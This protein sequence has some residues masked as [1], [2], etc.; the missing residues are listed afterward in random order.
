MSLEEAQAG[1]CIAHVDLDAFYVQVEL[2]QHPSLVGK[3]VGVVQYNPN[4]DLSTLRPDEERIFNSSNGSLIAVG[5]E[6]R[7]KGVKRGMR[8]DDARKVCP[9]LNLV[10]VPVAHGKADLTLY[11][12]SGKQVL[13]ILARLSIAERA[14]IDECYLDISEEAKKR[15]AA[16]SAHPPLPI[17]VDQVHV[18][19]EE[20]DGATEA[21]WHRPVGAWGPG[22]RLLACGAAVVAELRAAVRRELGYSCSAGIAHN[23][24]L[25]KLASGMHKPSQQTVVTLDCVPGLM[26]D[27]PI[28]KL[29]QLGGKFGEEIMAALGITSVGELSAVPLRRLEAVCGHADALWLHRLSRGI[30]DEEVK[31]RQLA[32]SISCGKTFRGHTAL[33][34]FPAVHKWLGEL[35]HE[36]EERIAADR[37]ENERVPRLL[38]V[39]MWGEGGPGTSGGSVSRSCQ[40]R[41]PESEPMAADALKLIKRWASER[42]PGWA[43]TSLYMTASNFQ[44]APTGA[45]TIT[46]FLKPRSGILLTSAT[47]QQSTNLSASSPPAPSTSAQPASIQIEGEP[48]VNSQPVNA[49]ANADCNHAQPGSAPSREA[50][51]GDGSGRDLGVSGLDDT[52]GADGDSERMAA[53][54]KREAA[55]QLWRG[56]NLDAPLLLQCTEEDMDPEVLAALPADIRRELRLALMARRP[57][58]EGAQ[59]GRDNMTHLGGRHLCRNLLCRAEETYIL[60]ATDDAGIDMPFSCRSGTCSS[61]AGKIVSGTLDQ[62]ESQ[63]LTEDKIEA[64]YALLCVSYPQSDLVIETDKEDEVMG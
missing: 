28:P 55:A 46:R 30:D 15:L 58:A 21:W 12:A 3:P 2:K 6:A 59:R 14:S 26:A 36:L 41:R 34:A 17:N 35:G 54:W 50:G 47:S 24:I 19:G 49:A 45:S 31:E 39:G 43:I 38:T 40:L 27:L 53:S 32:Q 22:Q 37:A 1:R 57:A 51:G 16:S 13:E 64:G 23:K 9:D 29:R 8:G 5:Y 7:A 4:G 20:G 33:K 11:R 44:A 18:C 63:F 60:D 62:S 42:G 48:A 61:C 10:Q 56:S 25:A 52:Q